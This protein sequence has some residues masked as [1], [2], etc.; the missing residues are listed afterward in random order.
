MQTRR[1]IRIDFASRRA[2]VKRAAS[3]SSRRQDA[4]VLLVTI[5][6]LR[7]PQ[8]QSRT[9]GRNTTENALELETETLQAHIAQID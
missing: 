1:E 5:A 7:P 3:G 9:A 6:P 4:R 8:R 2:A